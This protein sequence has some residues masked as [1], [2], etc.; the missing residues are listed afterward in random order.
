MASMLL[1]R[2]PWLLPALQAQC[3]AC[4]LWTWDN[5]GEARSPVMETTKCI[6]LIHV[7]QIPNTRSNDSFRTDK[8]ESTSLPKFPI[9]SIL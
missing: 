3:D 7:R 9:D 5:D 6:Q 4:A 1:R 8:M 2:Q